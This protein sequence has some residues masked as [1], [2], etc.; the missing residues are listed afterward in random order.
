M[1]EETV[2]APVH[3]QTWEQQCSERSDLPERTT[4]CQQGSQE[5]ELGFSKSQTFQGQNA[6][7]PSDQEGFYHWAWL[8]QSQSRGFYSYSRSLKFIL[9]NCWE[10]WGCRLMC[11]SDLIFQCDVFTPEGISYQ[12]SPVS[13]GCNGGTKQFVWA[14]SS[15]AKSPSIN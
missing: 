13:S 3:L 12:L 1:Q 5:A 14:L 10:D 2:P 4:H 11:L 7:Q 15:I 9:F 6:A 8:S